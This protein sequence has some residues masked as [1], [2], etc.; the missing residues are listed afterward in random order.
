MQ[1]LWRWFIGTSMGLPGRTVSLRSST[2]FEKLQADSARPLL[3]LCHS[4]HACAIG[5]STWDLRQTW[6][7]GSQGLPC[8][9]GPERCRKNLPKWTRNPS[10]PKRTAKSTGAGTE[11]FWLAIHGCHCAL[12]RDII[13]DKRA[14]D[15]C[16][17][18]HPPVE[19]AP[20]C[21]T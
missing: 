3:V 16:S 15:P 1:R 9:R 13:F 21:T 18:D 17:L 4:T 8:S 5:S 2:M 11:G 20:P 19:N 6:A 12:L 10:F 7:E 14:C